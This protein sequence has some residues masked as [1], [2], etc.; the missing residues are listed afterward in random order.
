M[1]VLGMYVSPPP[2]PHPSPRGRFG[3]LLLSVGGGYPA[4]GFSRSSVDSRPRRFVARTVLSLDNIGT[5]YQHLTFRLSHNQQ[6]PKP[7]FDLARR[8]SRLP[9]Y[10]LQCSFFFFAR[11]SCSEQS[12]F[13]GQAADPVWF[14]SELLFQSVA[15]KKKKKRPVGWR[16]GFGSRRVFPELGAGD[17]KNMHTMTWGWRLG[18]GSRSVKN[19]KEMQTKCKQNAKETKKCQKM[20][21]KS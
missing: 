20:Q 6:N 2:T 9:N 18:F 16:L 17:F 15:A 19:A 3:R 14:F 10:I 7:T 13:H 4:T 8:A 21:T 11:M 12:A 5:S 1:Y